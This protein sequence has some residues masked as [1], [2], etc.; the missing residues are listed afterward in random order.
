MAKRYWNINRGQHYTDVVEGSASGSTDIE[1][2][3][4]LATTGMTRLEVLL[5]INYIIQAIMKDIWPP[6]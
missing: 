6:A 2:N 1:I 5:G 4:N 3:I